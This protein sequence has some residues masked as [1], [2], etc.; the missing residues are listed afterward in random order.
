M[1]PV[2]GGHSMILALFSFI[3]ALALP[4]FEAASAVDTPCPQVR[5]IDGDT[6]DCAG[7]RIRLDGIDAPERA[8][9]CRSATL[10]DYPCGSESTRAL[11]RLV[12]S[13]TIRCVPTGTD[14]YGR[15]LATCF[16]VG[17]RNLNQAMVCSGDAIAY[18]RYSMAYLGAE[19]V[20]R[21]GGCGLWAGSFTAP[22]DWRHGG[23]GSYAPP[24][25]TA[26]GA[27]CDAAA[28]LRCPKPR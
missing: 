7:R 2:T 10:R 24:P 1:H 23:R 14:R 12:G 8:Q 15:T 27:P 3:I 4:A 18:R 28:P 13:G 11:A 22:E 25:A 19:T 17:G 21:S 20:A 5:V 6:L 26:N 9:I 16:G